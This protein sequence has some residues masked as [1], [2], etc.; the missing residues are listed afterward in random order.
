MQ[1]EGNEMV[2]NVTPD[3]LYEV[4][5]YSGRSIRASHSS[6]EYERATGR[7]TEQSNS[8]AQE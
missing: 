4:Q 5:P 6:C 1:F 2:L 7:H 3:Q 8:C